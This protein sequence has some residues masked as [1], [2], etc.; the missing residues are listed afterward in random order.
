VHLPWPKA[1]KKMLRPTGQWLAISLAP[2]RQV[3][4]VKLVTRTAEFDVTANIA[5]AAM[6]PFT[7][8]LG[9]DAALTAALEDTP[10]PQLRLVDA[11]LE[12]VIGSMRLKYVSTWEAAGAQI[13]LFEIVRAAHRCAPWP[14]RAWDSWMY[15]RAVRN[16]PRDSLLMAPPAV[17]QMLVFYLRPR[18]VFLVSVDDGQ[19]SNIF[20]MD[21]VGPLPPERFTL[22]LRNTSPSVETIKQ[23]RKV[24]M[25]DLPGTA[26]QIA[27]QLG[28]HHKRDQADWGNL[29][30]K[31]TLS[32]EF[33]LPVPG[34]ALGVREVEIL[35]SRTIGSHTLFVGRVRSQV[36][37]ANAA[38]ADGESG[39]LCHTAAVHQR[40]RTRYN[41]PFLEALALEAT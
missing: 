33:G 6:R 26:C 21:L 9:L 16:V 41:S 13:G 39:R 35:E 12:R 18:P 5:V 19:H 11:E 31:T 1:L 32:R 38:G 8:R 10:E 27:Y 3:V 34:I 22:A 24:A 17:E 28:A 7:L 20:P 23:A 37:G 2:E 40:L 29:P 15:E 4:A 30:F 36:P 25:A 14:R